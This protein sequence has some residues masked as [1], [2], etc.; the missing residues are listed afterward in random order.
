MFEC[1]ICATSYSCRK[2]KRNPEKRQSPQL[3]TLRDDRRIPSAAAT[4]FAKHGG[5]NQP[6]FIGGNEN[7]RHN[8]RR[9][10]RSPQQHRFRS[11]LLDDLPIVWT[12]GSTSSSPPTTACCTSQIVHVR[13]TKTPH[14]T[15]S[16][17]FSS[18]SVLSSAATAS[19][20]L[21]QTPVTL[22]VAE[23][24]A[25]PRPPSVAASCASDPLDSARMSPIPPSTPPC[26]SWVSLSPTHDASGL[27]FPDRGRG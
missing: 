26:K 19:L 4:C 3:P 1:T 8:F 13:F 21:V 11:L 5:K 25:P 2:G 20:S 14:P 24:T 16:S 22:P 9:A 6:A 23:G 7:F 15:E 18:T 17:G 10:Q 12:A 27:R